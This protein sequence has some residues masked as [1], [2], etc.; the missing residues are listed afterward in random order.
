MLMNRVKSVIGDTSFS[1]PL[2]FQILG[3]SYPG[4]SCLGVVTDSV[5]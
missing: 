4:M 3:S 2:E 5:F 1:W